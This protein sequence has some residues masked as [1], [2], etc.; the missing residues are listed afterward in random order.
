MIK[1]FIPF[2]HANNVFEIDVSFYL[3]NGINCLLIDLDN[4]LDAHNCLVPSPQVFKLKN[5][6]DNVGI[7]MII[8]SNNKSKRVK[9]YAD[10]LKVNFLYSSFKPLPFKINKFLSSFKCDKKNVMI[11]GDQLLTD[12]LCGYNLKI[13]SV[14]TEKIVDQDQAST[15]INRIVDRK[16]RSKLNKKKLLIDW[17]YKNGKN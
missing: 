8:T 7:K 6:L 5:D 2:A 10:L 9:K 1:R 16:I 11:I 13:K 15:K 17:R 4:T 3:D 12:V 14:L